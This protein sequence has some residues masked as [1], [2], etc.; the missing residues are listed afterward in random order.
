M[1]IR[2][3]GARGSIPVSG[4]EYLKYGGDTTCME[5]RTKDDEIIII[6]AGSGIRK[7]GNSLLAE[8]RHQYTMIFTH[9]HWDHLMGFP[10][11]KP[12]YAKETP[13]G[14]KT[15]TYQDRVGCRAISRETCRYYCRQAGQLNQNIPGKRLSCFCLISPD[16]ISRLKRASPI[17][18]PFSLGR[19]PRHFLD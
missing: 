17:A 9:A 11:F 8:D 19:S 5:V 6:D 1:I 12:I 15:D 10:V 2:Y 7:L 14:T 3:W 16:L 13:G 4:K 18:S